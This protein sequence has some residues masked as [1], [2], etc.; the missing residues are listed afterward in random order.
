MSNL[1]S[2]ALTI[3]WLGETESFSS[4]SCS[5]EGGAEEPGMFIPSSSP[6]RREEAPLDTSVSS[7]LFNLVGFAGDRRG[8]GEN[9]YKI[10]AILEYHKEII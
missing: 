10:C 8:E 3:S 7:S 1:Y 4:F 9:K 6:G 5:F 2:S